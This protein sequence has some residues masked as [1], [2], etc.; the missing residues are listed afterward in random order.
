MDEDLFLIIA[1]DHICITYHQRNHRIYRNNCVPSRNTILLWV[2][3][4]Q[5]T[6]SVMKETS[7]EARY[8]LNPGEY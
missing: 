3:N 2:I 6:A 5:E 4:F 1:C 7:K 8:C